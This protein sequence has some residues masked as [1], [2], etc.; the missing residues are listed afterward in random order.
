MERP[1]TP[2]TKELIFNEIMNLQKESQDD[3]K[4][5]IKMEKDGDSLEFAQ[6]NFLMAEF[7]EKQIEELKQLLFNK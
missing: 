6:F 1:L 4:C 7:K 3:R 5:A 2:L